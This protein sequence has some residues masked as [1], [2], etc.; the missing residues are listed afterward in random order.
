MAKGSQRWVD[1]DLYKET[2]S[3][4]LLRRIVSIAATGESICEG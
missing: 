1:P 2:P 3:I 4:D